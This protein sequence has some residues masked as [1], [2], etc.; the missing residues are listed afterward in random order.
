MKFALLVFLFATSAFCETKVSVDFEWDSVLGARLYQ[1]ELS[2]RTTKKTFIEESKSEHFNFQVP[3][4]KYKIRGRVADYRKVFGDW[5]DWTD[6]TIGPN[7]IKADVNRVPES[8]VPDRKTLRAEKQ[9][10]WPNASGASGYRIELLDKAGK[11]VESKIV[12]NPAAKFKLAPGE[13]QVR[14]TTLSKEGIE[15]E[16][17]VLADHISVSKSKFATPKVIGEIGSPDFKV[18]VEN[19]SALRYR[20][21]YQRH[22]AESKWVTLAEGDASVYESFVKQDLAAGKYRILLWLEAEMW[23]K[24]DPATLEY[25]LKPNEKDL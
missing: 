9:F 7:A 8:L 12:E 3:I 13:Y 20:I 18:E 23:G 6:L 25:V 1:V 15:S 10:T 4:G 24:S 14:V 22:L 11:I 19:E 17:V 2:D 5:S 16:T 21:E